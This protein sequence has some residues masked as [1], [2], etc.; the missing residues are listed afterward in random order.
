MRPRLIGLQARARDGWPTKAKA[1]P[2]LA[3]L[4]EFEP[5][6]SR[7]QAPDGGASWDA[8]RLHVVAL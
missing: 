2:L 8:A 5:T 7:S 3:A 6:V 1:R 4:Q